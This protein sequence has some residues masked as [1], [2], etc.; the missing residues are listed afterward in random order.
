MLCRVVFRC[1]LCVCPS[2]CV[3]VLC[4]CVVLCAACP[5]LFMGVCSYL[6]YVLC[7][8]LCVRLRVWVSVH[9]CVP[10]KRDYT[11]T[12]WKDSSLFCD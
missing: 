5:S 10:K 11:R 8:V 4:A 1:A 7:G 12:G 3:C 9:T 6:W 2:L